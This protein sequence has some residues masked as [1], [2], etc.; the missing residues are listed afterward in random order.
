MAQHDYN[1][2]NQAGASFRADLNNLATAVQTNN[3]STVAP[4]TT[5]QFMYFADTSTN[6]M[7]MRNESDSDFINLF[8]F[9]SSTVFPFVGGV[10]LDAPA[11]TDLNQTFTAGQRLSVED[12]AFASTIQ[13]NLDNANN[14]EVSTLT[15]NV[16]VTTPQNVIPGQEGSIWFTQDGTGGRTVSFNS[17]FK[18]PGGTAPTATT[19][20][21]AKDR[22][23]YKV[24]TSTHIDSVYTTDVK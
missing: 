22:L 5:D 2:A 6:I 19:T 15:G 11:Q 7:N 3:S 8:S 4:T 9:T 20:S 17:I 18:L 21:S 12:I 10:L 1:L 14:F 16:I 23:D 13:P 24:L